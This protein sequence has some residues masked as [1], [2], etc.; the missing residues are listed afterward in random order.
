MVNYAPIWVSVIHNTL[1]RAKAMRKVSSPFLLLIAFIMIV[2]LACMG[3]NGATQQPV[4]TEAP[5]ATEPPQPTAVVTESPTE[6]PAAP[7]GLVSKL[8]D[9]KNA[10]IQIESQGTFV[11]PQ[12]GVVVNG[13]G[14]GSGF[15]IDPSGSGNH[16]Q[17]CRHRFSPSKGLGWRGSAAAQRAGPGG[18]GMLRSGCHR[19]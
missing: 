17:P 3:S 15:I 19:H 13:A 12:V 16:E 14:R 7:A 2:G 4:A 10:V 9:V 6:P 1:R 18:F 5:K 11:D 8:Q